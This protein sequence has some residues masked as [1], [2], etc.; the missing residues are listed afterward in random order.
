MKS[1]T[2]DCTHTRVPVALTSYALVSPDFARSRS[3]K[4]SFPENR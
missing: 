2:L 3:P 4:F 1:S